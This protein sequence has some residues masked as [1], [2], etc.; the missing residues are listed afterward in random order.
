MAKTNSISTEPNVPTPVVRVQDLAVGT[1]FTIPNNSMDAY[2][3][4]YPSQS[5][6][7]F[8]FNCVNLAQG[9]R[10]NLDQQVVTKTFSHVHLK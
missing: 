6:D 4:I 10:H 8:P 5:P 3:K 2:I 9:S 7:A 1:L